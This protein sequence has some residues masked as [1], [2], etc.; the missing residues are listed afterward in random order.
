MLHCPYCIAMNQIVERVLAGQLVGFKTR[1]KVSNYIAILA[2]TGKTER[3]LEHFGKA[4]L[5][6]ML[7]PDT[8]YSGC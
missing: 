7:T 6:E 2:S 3:Q 1:E 4:Y 8:R 5:K